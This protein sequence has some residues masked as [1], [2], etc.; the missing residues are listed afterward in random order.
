M[1]M[2]EIRAPQVFLFRPLYRRAKRIFDL[3]VCLALLPFVLPVLGLCALLIWLEDPGSVFFTQLRTGKGGMRFKMYK[4]RTMVKNA[5]ELKQKYAH[6]NELTWPDFKITNDPRVTRV[7][8]FLRKT[9][10]D[11][12][13]QIFN[14]LKGD[15]SLVGPRPTSFDASTYALWHTERLEVLPGLTGLWQVSGRSNL[16]FDER[17]RLD[18]EYIERQS[19]WLDIEILLR[20]AI[21]IFTQHGAY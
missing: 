9:S 15:M 19:F 20:T 3:A 14:V 12:L 13:P 18:I 21:A 2:V 11:E 1:E 6:L 10:L 5:E 17:L 7:G 16:D 4:L 8:K